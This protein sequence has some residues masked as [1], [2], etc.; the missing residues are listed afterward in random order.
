[1]AIVTPRYFATIGAPIV[2]GREFTDDDSP[3]HPRV[4]IVNEAFAARFFPGQRAIGKR[5]ETGATAKSD[6]GQPRPLW[7]EIVGVVKNVRQAPLGG[8]PEPIYYLPF[9]QMTWAPPT[10]IVRTVGEPLASEHDVRRVVASID[11]HVPV[12][13]VNTFDQRLATGVA[14]PRFV[15]IV[16]LGFAAI[17]LL[18][19]ATGLYGLLAYAVLRRTREIGVRMALGATHGTIATMVIRRALALVAAGVVLG[20]MGAAA[21]QVLLRGVLSDIPVSGPATLMT[22]AAV[23]VLTGIAAAYVPASRA[24]AVD[25]AHTLRAD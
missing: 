14:G 13:D 21:V 16:M 12:H 11:P 20:A 15:L 19:T 9:K 10:L 17:A 6:D 22:S 2:A 3:Q 25:P 24:A 23:V 1:M 5:F 4:V 8:P 7:R 18:L